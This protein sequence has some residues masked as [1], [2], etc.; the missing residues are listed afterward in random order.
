M[1]FFQKWRRQKKKNDKNFDERK[2]KKKSVVENLYILGFRWHDSAD[3]D[4]VT[5]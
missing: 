4:R 3:V 1:W 2:G 5:L